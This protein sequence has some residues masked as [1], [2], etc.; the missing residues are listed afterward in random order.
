MYLLNEVRAEAIIAD[1]LQQAEHR[2]AVRAAAGQDGD[3]LAAEYRRSAR[4]S[5]RS[6]ARKLAAQSS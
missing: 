4:F 5:K 2:R 1:H 3:R 6:L